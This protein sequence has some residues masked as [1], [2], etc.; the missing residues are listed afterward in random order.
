M[1]HSAG[2]IIIDDE[3]PETKVLCVRAYSNWDFPKGQ[4][5]AGE[6]HLEAAKREVEE[7]VTLVSGADYSLTGEMAPSV[8][9]GSGKGRKTATYFLAKRISNVEPFLPVNPELGKPEND[10]WSFIPVSELAFVMPARLLKIV[11]FIQKSYS[12]VQ[13]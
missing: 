1:I 5:E 9:Y 2:I 13:K 4:L 6:S 7:E 12:F 3:G 10:Q 11:D 8:T